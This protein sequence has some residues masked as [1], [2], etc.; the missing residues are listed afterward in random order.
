MLTYEKITKNFEN[1][2]QLSAFTLST[3]E[4]PIKVRLASLTDYVIPFRFYLIKIGSFLH[5]STCS[6]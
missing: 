3:I 1:K 2:F 5:E 4:T 6:S